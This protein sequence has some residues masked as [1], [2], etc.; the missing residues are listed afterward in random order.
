VDLVS[1]SQLADRAG[2]T[3]AQ[4]RKDLSLFG[5]FGKRGRGYD[6]DALAETIEKI[7]GLSRVWRVGLVGVGKIGT[8]LL[9]YRDMFR[10]GFEVVAAFDIEPEKI[11]RHVS[12]I[13]V[14]PL[15]DLANVVRERDV[16]I[17]IVATPP[18]AAPDVAAQLAEAGVGAILN[19]APTELQEIDCVPVR[20]VDVVLELEGLSYL[21]SS[22]G[23]NGVD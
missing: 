11:G 3:S 14:S 9:G 8:A 20:T 17:A 2:A 6:V 5:S 12:G 19:F 16:Q 22:P 4:V 7:L 10:R 21:L 23:R 1:S 15:A 18:E 13:T